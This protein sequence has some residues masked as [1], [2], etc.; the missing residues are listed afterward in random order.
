MAPHLTEGSL[1]LVLGL[2]PLELLSG[3]VYLV[4]LDSIL[5]SLVRISAR[6][7]L[8]LASALLVFPLSCV[9][10]SPMILPLLVETAGLFGLVEVVAV[11]AEA[12]GVAP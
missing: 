1:R 9:G 3:L 11:I 12:A 4:A 2:L 8:R 6:I 5:S 7:G 10:L